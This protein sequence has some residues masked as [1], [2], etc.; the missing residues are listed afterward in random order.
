MARQIIGSRILHLDRVSSTNAY[1]M[2]WMEEHSFPEGSVI[3]AHEQYAG[4]GMDFNTWESEPGKNLTFSIVLY[5]DIL[6]LEKQFMLNK[7]VSLSLHD[8]MNPILVNETITIKWPNDL[9]IGD[10]KVAGILINNIIQGSSFVGTVV[11]IGF[12]INQEVFISSAPNPVSLKNVTG[13]EYNLDR[14]LMDLCE[15][16]DRRYKEL[17]MGDFRQMDYDYLQHQYR[18][19]TFYPFTF[20]KKRIL[21]K[22]KSVDVYGRLILKTMEG[23]E[24]RSDQK[25]ISYIIEG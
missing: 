1:A 13:Q 24:V 2:K 6:P 11:G 14:C 19:G 22:I 17:L 23:E 21:A 25:E 7:M 10:R 18:L 3:V 4:R 9:Y 8:F 16:L 12:N 15:N 20:R 5:P